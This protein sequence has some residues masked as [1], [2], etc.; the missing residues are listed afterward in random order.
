M[1]SHLYRL[2][3]VR[4]HLLLPQQHLC[5]DQI[6]PLHWWVKGDGQTI[7]AWCDPYNATATTS[8]SFSLSKRILFKML[9]NY[10]DMAS[11]MGKTASHQL[12]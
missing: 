3:L 6:A 7:A 8:A 12:L 9:F 2:L 4:L 5:W 10:K 1:S 11:S